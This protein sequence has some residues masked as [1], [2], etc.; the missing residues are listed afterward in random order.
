M[1]SLVHIYGSLATHRRGRV[2]REALSA[3]PLEN[4][5]S[6]RTSVLMFGEDFQGRSGPDQVQLVD[7]TRQ[8]GRVLL[9]LPPFTAAACEQPVAW[10]AERL[11]M[12]PRGGEGIAKTLA[13][14][15]TFR[16]TGQLQPPPVAGA[17]WSDL[18]VCVGAYRAHPAA[19]L[20]VAT[21]LPLWSLAVLD[22]PREADAWLESL[23]ALAGAGRA[24][25]VPEPRILEP[26]HFGFLV[27]LLSKQFADEEQALGELRASTVFKFSAERA[28]TLLMELRER[29][30]VVGAVPTAQAFELV[31][32]S[33]YAPYV[34]A[35]REVSS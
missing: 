21:C 4:L 6:E 9:L 26:D 20:F 27:Y 14:E 11:A 2:L 18:S 23:T 8:P 33:P 30:L 34:S 16:L 28:R 22:A 25:A 1:T 13:A 3:S 29:G 12:P 5:P 32:Q 31:M 15:V 19:G 7:W 35:V 10:R 24:E 17:T